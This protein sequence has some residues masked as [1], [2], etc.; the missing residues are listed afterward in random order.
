MTRRSFLEG[1][2]AFIWVRPPG[3]PPTIVVY[4]KTWGKD[5]YIEYGWGFYDH[6]DARWVYLRDE[7]GKLLMA[8]RELVVWP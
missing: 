3:P 6:E 2:A 7:N 5:V 8:H 4:Q 1:L